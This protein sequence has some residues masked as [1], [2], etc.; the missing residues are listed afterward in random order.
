MVLNTKWKKQHYYIKTLFTF[1][2]NK[3][4][5]DSQKIQF[6]YINQD[7]I[8]KLKEKNIRYKN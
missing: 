3:L 7:I 5:S 8:K 6:M 1:V 2:K 4:T